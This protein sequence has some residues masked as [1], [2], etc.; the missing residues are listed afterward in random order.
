MYVS[1]LRKS[2]IR[3]NLWEIIKA[4]IILLIF[5]TIPFTLFGQQ[6][7]V[8]NVN[9]HLAA[10][11]G[12]VDAVMQ[13]IKAG[14]DLNKKDQFGSTPLVIAVFLEKQMLLMY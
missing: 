11:Q 7:T 4:E 3:P 13:H 1:V 9:L 5:L 14:S 2:N 10:L 6:E 8:P 12:N